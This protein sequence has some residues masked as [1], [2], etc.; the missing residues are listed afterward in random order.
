MAS[1]TKMT[2]EETIELLQKIGYGHL[3]C[4]HEGKPHVIPMQYYLQDDAI[5]MFTDRGTKSHDLTENP[6]ICLQVEELSDTDN[7]SSITVYGR[8][9]ILEDSAEFTRIA[10]AIKSQN[11]TFSPVINREITDMSELKKSIAIYQIQT[12]KMT[13]TKA[14]SASDRALVG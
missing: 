4:I 9:E 1:I 5:Y 8:A 3:G 7:W 12:D 6:D 11:S 10:Q 2:T 13:G 14:T